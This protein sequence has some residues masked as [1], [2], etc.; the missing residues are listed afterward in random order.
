MERDGN[1]KIYRC[2]STCDLPKLILVNGI[3]DLW[4]RE[5]LDSAELTNC[6]RTFGTKFEINRVYY[7]HI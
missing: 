7:R 2:G 5:N 3:E 1:T 4:R 6:D